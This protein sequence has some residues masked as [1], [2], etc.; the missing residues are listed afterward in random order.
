MVASTAILVFNRTP[1]YEVKHKAVTGHQS[2]NPDLRAFRALTDHTLRAA[3]ASGLPVFAIDENDQVGNT[4]GQRFFNAFDKLF[5]AGYKKVIAVGNDHPGLSVN[6]ILQASEQLA[7]YHHVLG[8]AMDGGFYLM[9]LT[10]EAFERLNFQNLPWQTR[11][12]QKAYN[13]QCAALSYQAFYLEP[14]QD[15]DAPADLRALRP[16][17]GIGKANGALAVWL[18]TLNLAPFSQGFTSVS[19]DLLP[20]FSRTFDARG[21]PAF[22]VFNGAV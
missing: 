11:E 16:L 7:R 6:H 18:H 2:K 12:L 14:L 15:I 21:P 8:P 3:N 5:S 1:E 9:G 19:T 20:A 13:Q 17:F 22:W 10:S 4:F